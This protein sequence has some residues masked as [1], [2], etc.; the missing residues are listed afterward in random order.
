METVWI[1]I[2]VM[3]LI[4]GIVIGA[5]MKQSPDEEYLKFK[6]RRNGVGYI[7]AILFAICLY[8]ACN[9]YVKNIPKDSQLENNK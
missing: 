1:I 9:S 4:I 5:Q 7:M 3:I 8:A 2:A 6:D